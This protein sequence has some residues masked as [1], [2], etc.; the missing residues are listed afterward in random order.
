MAET[1]WDALASDNSNIVAGSDTTS[2]DALPA[3]VVKALLKP[4]EFYGDPSVFGVS[5]KVDKQTGKS[6][7]WTRYLP[8][9]RPRSQT[10]ETQ[11]DTPTPLQA[12]SVTATMEFWEAVTR[13]SSRARFYVGH[14][15]LDIS[16]KL[17]NELYHRLGRTNIFDVLMAGTNLYYGGGK[18]SISALTISDNDIANRTKKIRTTF[19]RIGAMPVDK[20]FYPAFCNPDVMDILLND[21]TFINAESFQG[22]GLYEGQVRNWL[23]VSWYKTNLLPV[24][25]LLSAIATPTSAASGGALSDDEYFYKIVAVNPLTGFA[26]YVTA[27]ASITIS[28]GGSAQ[29]LVFVMPA[30]SA[31]EIESNINYHYDI[32]IGTATGDSNLYRQKVGQTAGATVTITSALSTSTATAPAAPASGVKVTPIIVLAEQA[33][34]NT[35]SKLYPYGK[36]KP[37][38]VDNTP[39]IGNDTGKVQSV[40][41]SLDQKAIIL[42]NSRL[43]VFWIGYN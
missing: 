1:N 33:F 3:Y 24:R 42:N 26:E 23:G 17:H 32:Y 9:P 19:E 5:G 31:L 10:S 6:V 25:Q 22:R 35:S 34:G 12:V 29:T 38:V 18:A 4:Q 28:G 41:F 37:N 2:K 7:R 43:A 8:L 21:T 11:M 30:A 16:L 14:D 13:F 20:S 40:S 36:F 15:L 27:E 39:T